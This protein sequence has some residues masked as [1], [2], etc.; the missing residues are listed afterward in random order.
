MSFYSGNKAPVNRQ[1][2]TDR[3]TRLLIT[4][5]LLFLA[6]EFPQVSQVLYSKSLWFCGRLYKIFNHIQCLSIC[7]KYYSFLKWW[8]FWLK[9]RHNTKI[10]PCYAKFNFEWRLSVY[11]FWTLRYLHRKLCCKVDVQILTFRQSI[12]GSN[13]LRCLKEN[14]YQKIFSAFYD[15]LMFQGILGVLAV[16]FGEDFFFECYTPLGIMSSVLQMKYFTH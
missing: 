13:S 4:I 5:L 14:S 2:K 8:Q 7:A 16:V 6:T 10:Q 3:T 11:R 12:K 9:L 15:N 1:K